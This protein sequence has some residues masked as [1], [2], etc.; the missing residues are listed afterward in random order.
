[1]FP[2]EVAL[3]ATMGHTVILSMPSHVAMPLRQLFECESVTYALVLFECLKSFHNLLLK[4][5]V[6]SYFSPSL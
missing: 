6:N 3:F 4:F 2:A 5:E 1:M